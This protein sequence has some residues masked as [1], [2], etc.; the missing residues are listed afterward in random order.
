MIIFIS[1]NFC[2][3]V[4][5]NH[6]FC[7]VK[8]IYLNNMSKSLFSSS[9]FFICYVCF[10]CFERLTGNA[11]SL[12]VNERDEMWGDIF[13]HF[14]GYQILKEF[15][16]FISNMTERDRVLSLPGIRLISY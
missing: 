12:K 5:T 6:S 9:H 1:E 4:F 15:F 11:K 8:L 14:K 7:D 10:L 3:I 16:K 2:K 13:Y